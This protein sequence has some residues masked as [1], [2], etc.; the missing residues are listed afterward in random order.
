V[1]LH[2]LP[3]PARFF[4]SVAADLADGVAVL[5]RAPALIAEEDLLSGTQ[6]A[7]RWLRIEHVDAAAAPDTR[8]AQ[9]VADELDLD[10]TQRWTPALLA[11]EESLRGS[12]V[13]ID[14]VDR[15]RTEHWYRLVVEAAAARGEAA[16]APAFALAVAGPVSIPPPAA[17]AR[18]RVHWWWSIVSRLD[19]LLHV[20]VAAPELDAIAL[21]QIVTVA[22]QDLGLADELSACRTLDEGELRAVC[23]ARAADLRL[24][25]QPIDGGRPRSAPQRYEPPWSAG[26]VD[27]MDGRVH[28]HAGVLAAAANGAFSRRI[29]T[30]QIRALLPVLDEWRI[31]L[32]EHTQDD[33]VI[34]RHL[35]P[36]D[37]EFSALAQI[38]G[39][40]GSNRRSAELADWLRVTRNRL[41]H[42]Q[43]V[44]H[45]HV[46]TGR[47]LARRAGVS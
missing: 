43:T 1:L 22:G 20:A 38:L 27:V 16:D 23:V 3:G 34:A 5:V 30:A 46:T 9:V 19:M 8:C 39:R 7:G 32:I 35:L 6:A 45:E 12:V 11:G 17:E 10:R 44:S 4:A 14:G 26:A 37:L 41:A 2:E 33:G 29:W 15:S 18:F 28:W 47:E 13:W 42:L 31:R 25:D 40:S 24:P 21:E 36:V